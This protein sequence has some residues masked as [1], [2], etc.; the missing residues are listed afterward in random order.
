MEFLHELTDKF[1]PLKTLDFRLAFLEFIH[2]DQIPNVRRLRRKQTIE[3]KQLWQSLRAGRFAGFK[4]RRQHPVAG[5]VLDFFCAQ[6]KLSIELDG[7]AH[8]LPCQR[9]HDL[10]REEFLKS[11]DIEVLRFWNHQW[12]QNRDGVLLDIWHELYRRTGCTQIIRKSPNQRF[13]PPDPNKI[14]AKPP[15]PKIWYPP[16]TAP[17]GK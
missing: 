15:P 10:A 1:H 17:S 5:Y 6:A 9:Q 2:V 3:E 12:R 13:V 7:F 16:G 14:L 8:G 4:F 11:L